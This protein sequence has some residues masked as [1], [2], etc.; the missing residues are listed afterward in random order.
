MYGCTPLTLEHD[1]QV[2][3]YF[4]PSCGNSMV[5]TPGCIR[6]TILSMGWGSTAS[7]WSDIP[8]YTHPHHVLPSSKF[9]PSHYS[10]SSREIYPYPF[11]SAQVRT[12]RYC[13]LLRSTSETNKCV[14]ASSVDPRPLTAPGKDFLNECSSNSTHSVPQMREIIYST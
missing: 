12:I 6:T 9:P 5:T 11:P 3:N 14:V 2:W 10:I 4:L 13:M 1:P 7:L 8:A